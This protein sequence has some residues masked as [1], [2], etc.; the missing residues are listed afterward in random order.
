MESKVAWTEP[1]SAIVAP[2]IA[3]EFEGGSYITGFDPVEK[4]L[5]ATKLSVKYNPLLFVAFLSSTVVPLSSVVVPLSATVAPLSVTEFAGGSYT[6][7]FAPDEKF[8][9]ATKLSDKYNPLLFVAFL[10][11]HDPV[12]LTSPRVS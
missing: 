6:T 11:A 5:N 9:N 10:S 2:L 8:L 4:F 1:L 7:G 3:T 12:E